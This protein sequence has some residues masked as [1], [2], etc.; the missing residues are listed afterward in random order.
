MA[1]VLD[2]DN[3]KD[4]SLQGVLSDCTDRDGETSMD[5]GYILEVEL[6]NY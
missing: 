1:I 3:V 2:R 4:L 6:K 5:P